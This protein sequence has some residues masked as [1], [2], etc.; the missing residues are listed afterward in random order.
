MHEQRHTLPVLQMQDA[1]AGFR[2]R[3]SIHLQQLI[4]RHGFQNMHQG[5]AVMPVGVIADLS[6]DGIDLAAQKRDFA[7]RLVINVR[8]EQ[9]GKDAF[10]DHI[11]LVVKP[12]D[13]D[14]VE[15][16]GAVNG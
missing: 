14:C 2:Q 3:S 1:D 16:H 9:P 4:T 5:L 12:F 13:A 11:A 6:Q 10:A 7:D 15:M 8:S